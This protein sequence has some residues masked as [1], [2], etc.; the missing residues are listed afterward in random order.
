MFYRRNADTRL[1]TLERQLQADYHLD[2]LLAYNQELL[3]H[4]MP[5]VVAPQDMV[6]QAVRNLLPDFYVWDIY[7]LQFPGL[8]IQVRMSGEDSTYPVLPQTKDQFLEADAHIRLAIPLL[9]NLGWVA[10][11]KQCGNVILKIKRNREYDEY[12]VQWKVDKKINDARSYYTSDKDDAEQTMLAMQEASFPKQYPEIVAVPRTVMEPSGSI[13]RRGLVADQWRK[14]ENPLSLTRPEFRTGF[15]PTA[16]ILIHDPTN[17]DAYMTSLYRVSYDNQ[18]SSLS[19][20]NYAMTLEDAKVDYLQRL[21]KLPENCA[22]Q[23]FEGS[24]SQK[25]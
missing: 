19:N 21:L 7:E 8:E 20:G 5:L 24:T 13:E 23:L 1:R 16:V 4:G 15:Y 25:E 11:V 14:G 3:R 17:D 10:L 12:V 9:L 18:P 22:F 2:N 6:R